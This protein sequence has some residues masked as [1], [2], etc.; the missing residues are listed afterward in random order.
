MMDG[1]VLF[2]FFAAFLLIAAYLLWR[3]WGALAT[4]SPEEERFERR[5]AALNERQAHRYSDEEL[6]TPV[7]EE[8]AWRVMVERG[9]RVTRRD[10]STGDLMHRRAS[11]S[12]TDRSSRLLPGRRA[13]SPRSDDE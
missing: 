4:V 12:L 11:K 9:R 13:A 7:T 2:V 5:V 10:R 3:Y 6:A 8:D 1:L